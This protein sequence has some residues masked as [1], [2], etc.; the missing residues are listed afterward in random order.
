MN[1]QSLSMR[2]ASN[3]PMRCRPLRQ[4][5]VP[6]SKPE[7]TLLGRCSHRISLLLEVG[8]FQA[9]GHLEVNDRKLYTRR[10]GRWGV[11]DHTSF[12][13]V[14]LMMRMRKMTTMTM[15]RSVPACGYE[16]VGRVLETLVVVARCCLGA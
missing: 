14:Y 15:G 1:V 11:G 9:I 8:I 13:D 2:L 10:W 4:R 12:V 3:S 5:R 16:D 6:W 7:G